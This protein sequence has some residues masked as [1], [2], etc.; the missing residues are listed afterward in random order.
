MTRLC[1][2]RSVRRALALLILI[3]AIAPGTWWRGVR[4]ANPEEL[5]LSIVSLDLPMAR[6]L[7]PYLGPFK[8]DAVWQLDSPRWGFGGFSGLLTLPDGQLLAVSDKGK[9]LIVAPEKEAGDNPVFGSVFHRHDQAKSLQDLEAVT[10]DPE[11]G[12]IWTAQEYHNAIGRYRMNGGRMELSGF[13]A[14]D[15]MQSWGSNSGPEAMVRLDDGRF[16][17]IAEGAQGGEHSAVI[18]A[19]DPVV[20]PKGK[21]F[22]FVGIDGFKPTDMAQLPDG[23]VLILSRRPVW[24]A[25]ARFAGRMAIADPSEIEQGKMW[26][27]REVAKLPSH[28][29]SDNFEGLAIEPRDDGSVTI[30]MISDDNSSPLQR[31]LLW[32]MSVDPDAL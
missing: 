10:W 28:L 19:G 23:R 7:A 15:S 11:S 8:L 17:V 9:L 29:L 27:E 5:H 24:P 22:A 18:F 21:E 12:L 20:D 26:P 1:Y 14:P 3:A 25:P 31:T 2:L 4:A 16:V 32:K 30:W 6:E 13:S